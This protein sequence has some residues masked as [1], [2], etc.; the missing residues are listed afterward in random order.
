MR[1][2]RIPDDQITRAARHRYPRLGRGVNA[3]EVEGLRHACQPRLEILK[4]L[5]RCTERRTLRTRL[6][7]IHDS[8]IGRF[9]MWV[10]VPM[11]RASFSVSRPEGWHKPDAIH[12]DPQSRCTPEIAEYLVQPRML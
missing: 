4:D 10:Q 12:R 9:V 5:W 3:G 1:Q 6:G 7:E 8:L 11:E 2:L